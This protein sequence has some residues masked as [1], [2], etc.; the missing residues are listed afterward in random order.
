MTRGGR[1]V[2]RVGLGAGR[3]VEESSRT[4]ADSAEAVSVDEEPLG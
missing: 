2:D 3:S 4:A 1:V